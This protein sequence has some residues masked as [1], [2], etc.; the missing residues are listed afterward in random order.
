MDST[1]ESQLVWG[2]WQKEIRKTLDK[3][4]PITD[5]LPAKVD[6]LYVLYLL[7]EQ[8]YIAMKWRDPE[9]RTIERAWVALCRAANEFLNVVSEKSSKELTDDLQNRRAAVEAAGIKVTHWPKVEDLKPSPE[10][11]S[12][13]KSY[14]EMFSLPPYEEVLEKKDGGKS[15]AFWADAVALALVGHFK[16]KT[17]AAQWAKV[18]ELM[19]CA[20][21]MKY[22]RKKGIGENPVSMQ[23]HDIRRRIVRRQRENK[24]PVRR[25]FTL[26]ACAYE[27]K[28]LYGKWV[29]AGA[30]GP[31]PSLIHASSFRDT[32]LD[33]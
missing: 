24:L 25:R 3:A 30:S 31:C 7:R 20:P 27:L 29:K 21:E 5:T 15:D 17:G 6:R 23:M 10:L 2:S 22:K 1:V 28:R 14:S 4:K 33:T 19:N 32:G 8:T 9:Q 13:L 12:A 16:E 11:A 18:A 26:A